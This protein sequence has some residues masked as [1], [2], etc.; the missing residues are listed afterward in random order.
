MANNQWVTSKNVKLV[1]Q[2]SAV[3]A[4][5]Y[6]AAEVVEYNELHSIQIAMAEDMTPTEALNA[7]PQVVTID[8]NISSMHS[9]PLASWD[10]DLF[11]NAHSGD[12]PMQVQNVVSMPP[13]GSLEV[14]VPAGVK[15]GQ[16]GIVKAYAGGVVG[17]LRIVVA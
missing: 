15:A 14:V 6:K 9:D 7:N 1:G 8:V 3:P 4:P 5:D 13:S 16:T 2:T 12:F 11:F 10:Y 17:A